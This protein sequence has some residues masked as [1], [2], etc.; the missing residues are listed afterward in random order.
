MFRAMRAAKLITIGL[1]RAYNKKKRLL[2]NLSPS[3]FKE[4][5]AR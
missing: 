2:G 3:R 4:D 1:E 5:I